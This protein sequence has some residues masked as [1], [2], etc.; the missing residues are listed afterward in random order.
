MAICNRHNIPS[1]ISYNY[2]NFPETS[3]NNHE[4]KTP[5]K[6][7]NYE[8]GKKSN[9]FFDYASNQNL[10]LF[11]STLKCKFFLMQCITTN[12]HLLFICI[13]FSYVFLRCKLSLFNFLL[14]YLTEISNNL[15]F[16]LLFIYSINATYVVKSMLQYV[17]FL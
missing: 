9:I 15:L 1:S 16:A 6:C 7:E 8:L 13:S 12:E 3:C 14:N 4:R 2:F 10:R 11:H 5:I 17:W